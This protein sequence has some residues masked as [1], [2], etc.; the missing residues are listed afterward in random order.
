[1]HTLTIQDW[2]MCSWRNNV[3]NAK[4]NVKT[5]LDHGTAIEYVFPMI[6]TVCKLLSLL[7]LI[8]LCKLHLIKQ[9]KLTLLSWGNI[10]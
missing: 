3:Y 10:D 1:M 4:F 7:Q 6:I 2:T 9:R 8:K 5:C